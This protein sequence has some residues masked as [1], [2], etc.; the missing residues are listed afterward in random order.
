MLP[1]KPSAKHTLKDLLLRCT[2]FDGEYGNQLSNHLPMT[3]VALAQSGASEERLQAFFQSYSKRLRKKEAPAKEITTESWRHQL[4][5]HKFHTDYASFFS[6]EMNR[7]G[8]E[9]LLA[10]YV[11]EL[12]PG[13]SGG[14]FHGLIRLSYGVDME[15]DS[16]IVEGLAHWAVTFMPLIAIEAVTEI[17][18][19]RDAKS[20]FNEM[21]ANPYWATADVEAPNIFSQMGKVAKDSNFISTMTSSPAFLLQRGGDLAKLSTLAAEVYAATL[22]FTALHMITSCHGLRLVWPFVGDQKQALFYYWTAFKAAYATIRC[23]PGS[24]LKAAEEL[25]EWPAIVERAILAPDDHTIKLI[26]SCMSE[27]AADGSKKHR[28]IAAL[29]VGLV[30]Q[31]K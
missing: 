17:D 6:Q 20:L 4:G 2:E 24:E 3:L 10:T 28:Y 31:F 16:E 5:G 15:N 8:K 26:Y 19:S 21:A 1:T 30:R 9:K 23:P 18:F 22:D 7:L 11:P 29:R 12:M 27:E 14:A 25:P 13:V